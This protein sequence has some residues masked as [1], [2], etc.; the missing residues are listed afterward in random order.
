MA[1]ILRD[2]SSFIDQPNFPAQ[3]QLQT[4]LN[5]DKLCCR[6]SWKITGLAFGAIWKSVDT[7][8]PRKELLKEFADMLRIL[9]PDKAVIGSGTRSCAVYGKLLS[10]STTI[11]STGRVIMAYGK[12]GEP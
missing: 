11:W 10:E 12:I 4:Q 3:L 5:M 8:T 2:K 1:T 7:V 9:K 6:S